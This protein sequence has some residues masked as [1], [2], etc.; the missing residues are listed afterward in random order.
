[1]SEQAPGR[2]PGRS[3]IVP[4]GP[5]GCS[6]YEPTKGRETMDFPE[7]QL[8]IAGEW[9]GRA[10]H[11]TLPVVDPAT[12]QV[13]A[14]VP[15]ANDADLDAALDAASATFAEWRDTPA[16][17]RAAIMQRAAGLLRERADEIGRIQTLEEGKG[18]TESISEVVGAADL[19]Q[20]SAEEGRRAYGRIVPSRVHGGRSI[21]LREPLGPVA[22]F[23][24]WNFPIL[25]PARKLGAALAA[26]C[27]VVFKPA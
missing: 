6:S 8:L 12:E 17:D 2:A 23:T 22:A 26:G 20:W 1:M 14:E 18:L 10:G 7:L 5:G 27:P 25:I 11:D 13:L 9:R 16:A 15:I 24:P 3:D 4:C 21:V 19:L